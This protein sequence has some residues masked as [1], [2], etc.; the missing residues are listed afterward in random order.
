MPHLGI[1]GV[2]NALTP[3]RGG[4]T[5]LAM[6]A[7]VACRPCGPCAFASPS[8]GGDSQ[9]GGTAG[10]DPFGDSDSGLT[11]L[12]VENLR[13]PDSLPLE[14]PAR[15]LVVGATEAVREETV[16][17][18]RRDGDA[19]WDPDAVGEVGAARTKLVLETWD[20]VLLRLDAGPL[21]C[22][23]IV[24]ALRAAQRFPLPSVVAVV[25]L[26]EEVASAL[27]ALDPSAVLTAPVETERLVDAVRN[28]LRSGGP[29]TRRPQWETE[30]GEDASGGGD[31]PPA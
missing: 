6:S 28:G 31:E 3:I 18:L 25:P 20:L 2:G 7:P 12:I 23:E 24:R 8:K 14:G 5:V 26:D 13:I 1:G 22:Q 10:E 30:S 27:E 21:D 11:P 9:F 15:I 29:A 17:L 19:G 16:A 4:S